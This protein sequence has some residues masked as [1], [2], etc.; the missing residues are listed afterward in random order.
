VNAGACGHWLLGLWL[1]PCSRSHFHI[2]VIPKNRDK[3]LVDYQRDRRSSADADRSYPCHL[4]A[5]G[6]WRGCCLGGCLSQCAHIGQ[7]V[8][9]V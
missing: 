8:A 3:P 1:F 6:G 2:P 9:V 7:Y 5:A 4:N